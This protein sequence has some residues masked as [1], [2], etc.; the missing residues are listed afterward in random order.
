MP[1][2]RTR[3]VLLLLI[4]L[5][6]ACGF[7]LR[8]AGGLPPEMAMT[9]L[10]IEDPHSAL[11]RRLR[12]LLEQ[13]GVQLV[14]GSSATAVLEIPQ[15]RV[16]T[17]VLTIADN[18]RVREYRIS[19]TVQFRLMDADGR[20]LMGLQTLRQAREISFDEQKILASS[21]EQEYLKR[22]LAEDLA[23]LIVNRL[24]S[25]SAGPG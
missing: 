9:E 18:A 14:G 4:P 22:D 23:R 13:S 16:T 21:R 2:F 12:T 6:G 19:H 7:Q 20:E 8:G 1:A 24:E 17:D 5:L 10:V 11:A 3:L 15:N 25:V